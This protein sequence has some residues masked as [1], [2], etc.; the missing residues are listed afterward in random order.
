MY[1]SNIHLFILLTLEG[2]E[3][4]RKGMLSYLSFSVW[5]V[6][7]KSGKVRNGH[8]VLSLLCVK[9]CEK[10]RKNHNTNEMY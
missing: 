1:T 9:G 2:C 6:V 10:I 4:F 3:K 8:L 7:N 5:E